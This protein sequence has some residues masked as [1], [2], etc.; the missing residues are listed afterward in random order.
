MQR[1]IIVA[2]VGNDWPIVSNKLHVVPLM[3]LL[4]A[5]HTDGVAVGGVTGVTPAQRNRGVR[6]Q[7][8][9]SHRALRWFSGGALPVKI[10]H[11]IAGVTGNLVQAL[12]SAHRFL[13][14]ILIVHDFVVCEEDSMRIMFISSPLDHEESETKMFPLHLSSWR[15]PQT[16]ETTRRSGCWKSDCLLKSPSHD[17]WSQYLQQTELNSYLS[18]MNIQYASHICDSIKKSSIFRNWSCIHLYSLVHFQTKT[19]I[20]VLSNN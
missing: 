20:L 8:P 11:W 3:T 12:T 15:W 17:S 6:K 2:F 16:R 7:P 18:R 1:T 10:V 9:R 14:G 19:N 5:V 13:Y 4:D